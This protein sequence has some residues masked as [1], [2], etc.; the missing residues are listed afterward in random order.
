[1]TRNAEPGI[2]RATRFIDETATGTHLL[3]E[4]ARRSGS[5]K[6]SPRVCHFSMHATACD[7]RACAPQAVAASGA[8]LSTRPCSVGGKGHYECRA[9]RSDPGQFI[10][11][12]RR[13]L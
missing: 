5:C 6:H 2:A 7:F 12:L 3:A 4:A 13:V 9:L 11:R 1:M 8:G 10:P